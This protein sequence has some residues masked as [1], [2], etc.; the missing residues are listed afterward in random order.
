MQIMK[1]TQILNIY[2]LP[3]NTK[4]VELSRE[5]SVTKVAATSV[6]YTI[7]TFLAEGGLRW[8]YKR[9]AMNAIINT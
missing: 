1:H 7:Y 6:Q 5:R 3:K 9:E 8:H 2:K 4:G